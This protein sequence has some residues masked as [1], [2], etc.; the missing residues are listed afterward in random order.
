MSL[1]PSLLVG[2][3]AAG[4]AVLLFFFRDRLRTE[5]EYTFTNGEL[6]FAQVFNNNKRKNLGSR[7][8]KGV[9]AF[10]KVASGS[11]Q[12]YLSMPETKQIRWYLNRE[13]ELYYFFYQKEGKKS[14]LVFEPSE[15]MVRLIRLYL[16]RGV[17]QQN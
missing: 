2:L 6:D 10:G 7:K 8:V 16:P 5:Y 4:L 12:R 3:V 15:E 13:A 9:D 17:E 11:F 1:L 14:I